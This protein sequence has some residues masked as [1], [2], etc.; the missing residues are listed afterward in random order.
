M[1]IFYLL[2]FVVLCY[3]LIKSEQV[4]IA[5]LTKF[6]RH[7]K[8]TEYIMASFL[9]LFAVALPEL[10]IALAASFD[11]IP[12]VSLGNVLGSNLV[13]LTFVLGLVVILIG[14]IKIE[15]KII[16]RDAWIAFVIAS[17]PLLMMIWGKKISRMEGFILLI[18]FCWYVYYTIKIRKQFKRRVEYVSDLV[19]ESK[20]NLK[21]VLY[22]ILACGV[23]IVS[24]WGM[25]EVAKL[26]AL[27][28][29]VPISLIAVVLI[30]FGTALPE[31]IFGIKATVL[32][33]EGLS[34]E[35][36]I[37]S[38]MVNSTFIIGLTAIINPIKIE[39]FKIIMIAGGFM[40]LAILLAN[41][42]LKSGRKISKKEGWI[43]IGFYILFLIAEFIFR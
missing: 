21:S 7:F 40:F 23:L 18:I 33:H 4:L 25:V 29:Y 37:S 43:L 30:A 41:I 1:I 2:I 17:L 39:N 22:F 14:G 42:F 3:F 35:N 6:S 12:I 16:K 19:I 15:S 31:L 26:I 36:I 28:L 10:V 13:N 11:K 34:F 27:N 20:E 24:S 32:R 9:I 8:F 5:L 38:I